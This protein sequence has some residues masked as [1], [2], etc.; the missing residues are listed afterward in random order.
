M[1]SMV[2]TVRIT[3]S[4]CVTILLGSSHHYFLLFEEAKGVLFCYKR[5]G[6]VG[7]LYSDGGPI[8]RLKR[9]E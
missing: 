1:R 3:R 4:S 6:E 9:S 7:I 8:A 2:E 5:I